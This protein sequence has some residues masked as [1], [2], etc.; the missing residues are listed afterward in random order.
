MRATLD[1]LDDFLGGRADDGTRRRI[2]AQLLNPESP[3]RLFVEGARGRAE[4]LTGWPGTYDGDAD[5]L[6]QVRDALRRANRVGPG[7][8]IVYFLSHSLFWL[9]WTMIWAFAIAL[10]SDRP[11]VGLLLASSGCLGGYALDVRGTVKRGRP[12]A[13]TLWEAMAGAVAG[14]FPFAAAGAFLVVLA[15]LF[16]PERLW[17]SIAIWLFVAGGLGSFVGSVFGLMSGWG[18]QGRLRAG[19]VTM[20]FVLARWVFLSFSYSGV[21]WTPA[22]IAGV[23][24][25]PHA[26]EIVLYVVSLSMTAVAMP[27]SLEADETRSTFRQAALASLAGG[28]LG[29]I[30][31]V[32]LALEQH[33]LLTL[34]LPPWKFLLGSVWAFSAVS[35][36]DTLWSGFE[37]W[38]R[39]FRLYSRVVA[40]FVLA[41]PAIV[42]VIAALGIL[43]ELRIL[44]TK[45]FDPLAIVAIGGLIGVY[46]AWTER[47]VVIVPRRLRTWLVGQWREWSTDEQRRDEHVGGRARA[48]IRLARSPVVAILRVY[49]ALIDAGLAAYSERLAA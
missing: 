40:T 29:L 21:A 3:L 39:T 20:A 2:A 6:A 41:L 30:P 14:T 25:G 18:L 48:L 33:A 47:W 31:G 19:K 16:I 1:E 24:F 10:V 27:V 7:R 42:V 12:S 28:L 34:G 46:L 36:V 35:C 49:G 9:V 11:L 13:G 44:P 38:Q 43:I 5:T 37:S 26:G 15:V 22:F 4:D 8:W 17:T 23:L 45:F 32:L